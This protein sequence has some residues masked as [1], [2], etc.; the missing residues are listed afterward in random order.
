[1]GAEIDK[2]WVSPDGKGKLGFILTRVGLT[3]Q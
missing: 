1:V 3:G 2:M